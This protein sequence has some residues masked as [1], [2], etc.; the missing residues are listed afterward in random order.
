[1]IQQ[2]Q[3]NLFPVKNPNREPTLLPY[4]NRELKRWP[5]KVFQSRHYRGTTGWSMA[6]GGYSFAR[7][8]FSERKI[9]RR[10]LRRWWKF[11]QR[12]MRWDRRG[13]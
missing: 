3:F 10:E 13:E 5:A 8:L 2:L 6:T 12:V 11:Y 1:M 7:I 4:W 9:T